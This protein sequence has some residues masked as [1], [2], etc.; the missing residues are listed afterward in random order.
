[1]DYCQGSELLVSHAASLAEYY[2]KEDNKRAEMLLEE[3][4]QSSRGRCGEGGQEDKEEGGG[5][6]GR[7]M[8]MGPINDDNTPHLV[9]NDT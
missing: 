9:Q 4:R 3:H 6:G 2:P 8:K 5:E 7:V 1:M